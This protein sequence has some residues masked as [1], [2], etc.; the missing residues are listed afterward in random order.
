MGMDGP[1]LLFSDGMRCWRAAF[2][3]SGPLRLEEEDTHL[4]VVPTVVTV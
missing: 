1:T 4:S 3:I 2:Y